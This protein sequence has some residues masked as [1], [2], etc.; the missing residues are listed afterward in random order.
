MTDEGTIERRLE[1]IEKCLISIAKV[2]DAEI[3]NTYP[4][5]PNE[6]NIRDI[7]EKKG[8]VLKKE[9]IKED[10]SCGIEMGSVLAMILSYSICKSIL[11]TIVHGL[12]SWGYVIYFA[13]K[14]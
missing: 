12:F 14:Y 4:D 13:I 11:W 1:K 3:A 6:D 8:G 10:I 5:C 7:L 9:T 2:L